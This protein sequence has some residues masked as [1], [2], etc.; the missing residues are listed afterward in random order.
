[1]KGLVDRR[2]EKNEGKPANSDSESN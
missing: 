2:G 1:V